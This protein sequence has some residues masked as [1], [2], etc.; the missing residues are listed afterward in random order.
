MARALNRLQGEAVT[1][2]E[3]PRAFAHRDV[4]EVLGRY[5]PGMDADSL[6]Q[7]P[8][9]EAARLSISSG[10]RALVLPQSL[11]TFVRTEPKAKATPAAPGL[12]V[13]AKVVKFV[14]FARL[15]TVAALMPSEA[16]LADAANKRCEQAQNDLRAGKI[17]RVRVEDI[18]SQQ[19][20][21]HEQLERARPLIAAYTSTRAAI[22]SAREAAMSTRDVERYNALTAQLEAL[23][24]AAHGVLQEGYNPERPQ[25][26]RRAQALREKIYEAARTLGMRPEDAR[27]LV[28]APREIVDSRD[29]LANLDTMGLTD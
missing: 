14:P 29:P 15:T 7:H 28:F 24:N 5:Y 8:L 12:A 17:G 10:E 27:A 25:F 21:Q 26:T 9:L 13:P 11:D 6:R 2:V 16:M 19:A 20:G 22:A 3:L 4:V 23:D 18:R 1:I